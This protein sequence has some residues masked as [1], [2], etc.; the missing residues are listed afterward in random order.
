MKRNRLRTN[1][2]P[3]TITE[4]EIVKQQLKPNYFGAIA[5]LLLIIAL[6]VGLVLLLFYNTPGWHRDI[7]TDEEYY[8]SSFFTKAHGV[9]QLDGK[10][11][12][13]TSDGA[14]AH[15]VFDV[16]G[17]RCIADE[18]GA[19]VNGE[20]ILDGSLY[21]AQNG[22]LLCEFKSVGEGTYEPVD[23]PALTDGALVLAN[24]R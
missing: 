11:L 9:V 3:R 19:A 15:G 20:L 17:R 5:V 4:P 7:F 8:C 22:V 16:D 13:F 6:T 21:V 18:D 1:P 14:L 2:I 23:A 24:E 10:A 12:C